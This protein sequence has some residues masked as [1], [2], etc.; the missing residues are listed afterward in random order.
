[1]NLERFTPAWPATRP[2]LAWALAFV[3]ALSL[4]ACT[5]N[6]K[7]RDQDL[8]RLRSWFPGQYDNLA[9]VEADIAGNVAD[10]REPVSMVIVPVGAMIMGDTVFYVQ[11]SDAM[12]P[13]RVLSQRLHRFEKSPDGESIL[14]TILNLKQ[15]DRWLGAGS[16]P[17]LLRGIVPD[18][19][20]AGAG[21]ALQWT[22]VDGK[23][24]ATCPVAAASAAGVPATPVELTQTELRLADLSFN[25]R[26]R[27]VPSRS[28]D[29]LYRFERK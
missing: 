24:T 22:F 18:D 15:P 29:P 25:G 8:S 5:T 12:S 19:V 20:V 1:M 26:V 21:C 28:A 7:L 16:D 27:A 4:Q 3:L 13:R 2:L 10:V 14:H 11:Q 23:F 17:D 9:Q 6:A